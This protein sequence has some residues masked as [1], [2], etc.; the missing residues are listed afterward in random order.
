MEQRF[1]RN[2]SGHTCLL[3]NTV[4]RYKCD[5]VSISIFLYLCVCELTSLLRLFRGCIVCRP[6][7]GGVKGEV[8]VSLAPPVHLSGE[9][10]GWTLLVCMVRGW[11]RGHMEVSWRTPSGGRSSAPLYNFAVHGKLRDHSSV[12]IITVA[13]EDWPAYSCSVRHQ[14]HPRVIRRHRPAPSGKYIGVISSL[15]NSMNSFS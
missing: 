7:S 4:S 6:G 11:R 15:T 13:T 5:C 12:A 10:L 14:Q 2:Q 9:Q 8:L 3:S 1:K